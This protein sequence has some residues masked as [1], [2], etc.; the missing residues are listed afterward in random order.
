[1]CIQCFWPPYIKIL[2][3]LVC[4]YSTLFDEGRYQQLV[5]KPI[6]L[7]HTRPDIVFA[8]SNVSQFMYSSCKTHIGVVYQ[9][10]RYLKGTPR[11]GLS[12][13]KN[14]NRKIEAFTEANCAD[15]VD[16]RRSTS[17]YCTFVWGNLVTWRSKKQIVVT[18]SSVGEKFRKVTRWNI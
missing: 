6:Y 9:I 15:F 4:A 12:F 2:A 7:T 10:L 3:P 11:R 18:R 17:R 16:D 8:V 1:M 5:E 13:K 14:G